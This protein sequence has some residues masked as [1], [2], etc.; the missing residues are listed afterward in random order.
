M[1]DT[2]RE[3]Q[4]NY[5][6]FYSMT[7][8]AAFLNSAAF[9][10]FEADAGKILSFIGNAYR[11]AEETAQAFSRLI[12]GDMMKI[13]LVSDYHALG[14]LE[15]LSDEDWELL[16][17]YEI[18]GRALEEVN[19]S[20]RRGYF[21]ASSRLNQDVKAGM[22]Y[23]S[24]H[25]A[26]DPFVRFESLKQQAEF[27]DLNSTR[28]LALLYALGIGTERDIGKAKLHFERCAMWGDMPSAILLKELYSQ[29][30]DARMAEEFSE[31]YRL[32]K[33]YLADGVIHPPEKECAERI[34]NRYLCTALIRQY[35]VVQSK[36]AEIDIAFLDAISQPELPLKKKLHYI[37]R[38]KDLTW[39][40]AIYGRQ[41]KET[42]GLQ[43]NLSGTKAPSFES[44]P[45]EA[46]AGCK[47]E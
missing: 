47:H 13:G 33:K 10:E 7:L 29:E 31:L 30:G 42:I 8:S 3:M 6:A 18:K 23:E 27:G 25:H 45:A 12:L 1:T 19:R 22:K 28:Q 44:M 26:Y 43:R 17:F 21:H 36:M 2:K 15:N 40:N 16:I 39:K 35:L 4:E 20:D 32:E 38:Y 5:E 14:S 34:R 46:G 11:L 24:F 37:S 41:E 9:G